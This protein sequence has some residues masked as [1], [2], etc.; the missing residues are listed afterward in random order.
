MLKRLL[1][2]LDGSAL[3]E[4]ALP[5]A[6]RLAHTTGGSV[7]LARIVNPFQEFGMYPGE[8]AP[9]L[10]DLLDEVLTQTTTYLM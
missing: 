9:Y 10:Q 8:L 4:Q 6:A 1:V 2:P 7:L 5:L 3:A